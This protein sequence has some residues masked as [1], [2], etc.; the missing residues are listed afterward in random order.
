MEPIAYPEIDSDNRNPEQ[1]TNQSLFIRSSKDANA[2]VNSLDEGFSNSLIKG[3]LDLAASGITKYVDTGKILSPDDVPK[4]VKDKFP[5]GGPE[6]YINFISNQKDQEKTREYV[7]STAPTGLWITPTKYVAGLAGML[8]GD[9]LSP[10]VAAKLSD[11][12]GEGASVLKTSGAMNKAKMLAFNVG[13]GA[14]IGASIGGLQGSVQFGIQKQIDMHPDPSEII[15]TAGYGGLFGIAGGGLSSLV[16]KA[17]GVSSSAE[18]EAAHTAMNHVS[19]DNQVE[20]APII[21]QG[22]AKAGD[23]I[24]EAGEIDPEKLESKSEELGNLIKESNNKLDEL[25]EETKNPK[26]LASTMDNLWENARNP[27][28][29]MSN[30]E[31]A[32]FKNT[33][34]VPYLQDIMHAGT[35]NPLELHGKEADLLNRL[36]KEPLLEH[37]LNDEYTKNNSKIM[38]K[39]QKKLIDAV[40]KI[41]KTDTARVMDQKIEAAMSDDYPRGAKL[42]KMV[43]ELHDAKNNLSALAK[44][45]EEIDSIPR[46][47]IESNH[48]KLQEVAHQNELHNL[49]MS[50]DAQRKVLDTKH[51]NTQQLN[52]I[53]QTH[54]ENNKI[55]YDD[56]PS[57]AEDLERV[58]EAEARGTTEQWKNEAK[59][60]VESGVLDKDVIDSIEDEVINKNEKLKKFSASIKDFASCMLGG[61]K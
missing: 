36:A 41:E 27:A 53:H 35:I 32:K 5:K 45:K 54:Q 43:D 48:K 28:I 57:S 56:G 61:L 1:D 7:A 58:S 34:K 25:P 39:L 33:I 50:V 10:K 52:D 55:A 19:S 16:G 13:K 44:R 6:N 9:P 20:V 26:S 4:N 24:R 21:Q 23:A 12:F 2:V 40:P 22:L 3:G 30:K 46:E 60:L 38:Y 15:A 11:V 42:S 17:P 59:Q 18:Y 29:D 51:I 31:Y 8:V 49:K 37:K 47:H 14:A